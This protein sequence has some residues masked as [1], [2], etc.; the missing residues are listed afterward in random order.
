M[1]SWNFRVNHILEFSRGYMA[2][3]A[4]ALAVAYL[5]SAGNQD[6]LMDALVGE[7]VRRVDVE[8]ANELLAVHKIEIMWSVK[9]IEHDTD[10]PD[11]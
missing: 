8:G 6:A 10:E 11:A 4:I 9:T 5:Y 1:S 2:S 3:D 7:L